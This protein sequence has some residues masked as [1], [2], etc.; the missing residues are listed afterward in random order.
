MVSSS[1][2]ATCLRRTK[3]RFPGITRR[4]I[5]CILCLMY[6]RQHV[7]ALN[8][9]NCGIPINQHASI[10]QSGMHYTSVSLRMH[11]HRNFSTAASAGSVAASH[12]RTKP[13]GQAILYHLIP[14][15]RLRW[16]SK[17]YHLILYTPGPIR[18]SAKNYRHD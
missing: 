14:R 7:V 12:D 17:Q 9:Q 4:A 10:I 2:G 1:S 13:T 11:Y 15:S 6:E 8:I 16:Y 5:S 3:R 18:Q